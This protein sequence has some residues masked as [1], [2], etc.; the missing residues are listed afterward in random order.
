MTSHRLV[1]CQM[2][3]LLE[4]ARLRHPDATAPGPDASP[5]PDGR[6]FPR[7]SPPGSFALSWTGHLPGPSVHR[8]VV[9][10]LEVERGATGVL[11]H[12]SAQVLEP[13]SR[14]A[15]LSSLALHAWSGRELATLARE[16]ESGVTAAAS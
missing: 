8:D 6:W 16:A 12:L 10:W 4:L 9:W 5:G 14:P 11:A 7:S 1:H 2:P 3:D 13:R 15:P